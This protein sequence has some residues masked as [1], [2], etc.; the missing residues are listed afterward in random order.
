MPRSTASL[1]I[2]VVLLLSACQGYD[3]TINE[4]VV[5]SPNPLFS[6]FDLPDDALRTCVEQ[7]INDQRVSAPAQLTTLNCSHAGI[8]SL[9]GLAVFNGLVSL[10]LSDNDIRNLVELGRLKELRSLYLQNND[11][12]DPV[13]LAGLPYLST[14]DLSGNAAL[15]CPR[16]GTFERVATLALPKHCS[17]DKGE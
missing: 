13:P 4:K 5:Y 6:D 12:V 2:A 1:A 16:A 15:Q 9:E 3:Y 14:L 17:G 11:I 7:A 10:K 8:A